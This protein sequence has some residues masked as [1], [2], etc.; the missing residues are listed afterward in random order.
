MSYH[1]L[2]PALMT[3]TPL[4]P[5]SFL[6]VYQFPTLQFTPKPAL[7]DSLRSV[8]EA[9][10]QGH[11]RTARKL[12]RTALQ[13]H[14][15]LSASERAA[16]LGARAAAE[17]QMGD[18]RTA[19]AS[20]HAS[21]E[22]VPGQWLAH[23]VLLGTFAMDQNTQAFYNHLTTLDLPA[24]TPAWDEPPTPMDRHLATASAAWKLREWDVVAAE[25]SQAHPEGVEGMPV[26]LQEDWFRLAI[27]R[28]RPQDAVAAAAHLIEV[29]STEAADMLLQALVQQGWNEE[30]LPLY[31]AVFKRTPSPLLRRR[32]MGLCI[33]TGALEEARRLSTQGPLKINV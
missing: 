5:L 23:R 26:G 1:L 17:A 16:L 14:K 10:H 9:M 30:A 32:L 18:V 8:W 4:R 12:I 31:R 2:S 29:R 11:A 15:A 6:T 25:L 33:R 7:A 20:A 22:A 21:L 28:E 24:E 27:Y 19:R 13:A 3:S